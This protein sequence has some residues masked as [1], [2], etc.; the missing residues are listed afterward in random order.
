MILA[1]LLMAGPTSAV[2]IEN[3]LT[4]GVENVQDLIAKISSFAFQMALALAPV[5][6]IIA[7]FLFITSAGDPNRVKTAKNLFWYTVVGL[8]VVLMATS[9]YHILKSILGG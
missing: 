3:P 2:V 4:G 5:M 1:G 7:G 6:F 9:F 8:V